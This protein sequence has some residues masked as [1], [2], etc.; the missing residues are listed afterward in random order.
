MC[1]DFLNN[2]TTTN[3]NFPLTDSNIEKW[4]SVVPTNSQLR[5]AQKPFNVFIHFGMNT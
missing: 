5:F 2:W 4:I 1:I 3:N